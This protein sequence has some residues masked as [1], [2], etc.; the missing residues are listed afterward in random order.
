MA[1]TSTNFIAGRM[2]KSVDERLVPPGEYVDALNVRLGSTENTE[3]GAVENSLGN[4]LL[5]N[6]TYLGS[7]LGSPRTIGVYEDGINETI[8][9]FVNDENNAASPTGTVDL[10]L[11]YHTTTGN[12]TYHV[13][14]TSVL[15]FDKEYL[16]TGVN[17]IENLLFFT[18]N[19]NPP[20]MINIRKNPAYPIPVA[21]IDAL[22]E[23]D[24]SVILNPPGFEDFDPLLGQVTPLGAPHVAPITFAS[25]EE[26]YMETRF[27]SFA[28]RY[29]YED[30]GYSATSLFTTPAFQ[31]GPFQFSIQNYLNV[32]MK[33]RYNFMDVTVST[34]SKRVVEINLLYKQTTSNVIYIAKRF[35]K[36]DMGLPNNDFYTHRFSNSEI[37]TTLGSDEL[38]RLYDNVPR[39]AKAQTIQGNRLIYGNY[40]D[41]YDIRSAIDGPLIPIA[42]ESIAMW[43]SI[44][45][46]TLGN[47]ST[48]IFPNPANPIGFTGTYVSAG[49]GA[50]ITITDSIIEWD[51]SAAN[52]PIGGVINTG[53]T[54]YFSFSMS[55]DQIFCEDFGGNT[56]CGIANTFTQS[57]PFNVNL[58]FTCPVN[59]LNVDDMVSSDEFANKI[60]GASAQLL[61]SGTPFV[62]PNVVQELYPCN[63]S[64][65]GGTLSDKFYQIAPTPISGTNLELIS[66]GL[67]DA[68]SLCPT[69][70]TPWPLNC[71]TAVVVGGATSCSPGTT[72]CAPGL[73]TDV[74]VPNW[75]LVPGVIAGGLIINMNTGDTVTII[76]VNADSTLSIGAPFSSATAVADLSVDGVQYQITNP[77]GGVSPCGPYGF[78]LTPM[79]AGT[80][81]FRLQAPVTQYFSGD[82]VAPHTTNY[83][84]TFIYYSFI[85]FSTS[86][87]YLKTAD[88]GSLHSNRDY[89]VGIVYMDA[90]GR[91]STVL[92]SNN[93]SV[94]FEP[95]RSV[96]KNFIKVQL[97]NLPPYWAKKYK[98]VIKPSEG[99]YSTIYSNLFYAQD[100]TAVENTGA[101]S[102]LAKMADLSQ[103]WFRLMGDNQNIL[104]VGDEVRCK[105]DT[106][107]AVLSDARST[108]LAIEGFS[109]KGITKTSLTGLYMLIKPDG[110]S[111]ELPSNA[112]YYYPQINKDNTSTSNTAGGCINNFSLN[113]SAGLPY[114]LPAGS[115]IRIKISNW[116][117]GGGGRCNSVGIRFD[118]T[119]IATS[120]YQT[121]HQWAVGDDLQ[122]QMTTGNATNVDQ[123]TLSFNPTLNTGSGCSSTQ[124]HVTCS[125]RQDS[126]GSQFF[127]NSGGIQRCWEWTE[128]YNGHIMLKIEVSRAPGMFCFETIPQDADPNLFYDASELLDISPYVAGGQPYHR[129]QRE[130][131]P[132]GSPNPSYSLPATNIDQSFAS[133]L[134]TDLTTYNCYTFGNGVESYRI[135]DSPAG[136]GFNLG[137]RTLAVSNQDYK[138]ANRFA[139]MTYSGVFSGAANSNNLNEFN[140]G[141]LNFKDCE[142]S[143]GPIQILHSRETD[144]LCLQED[145]ISYVLSKKNVIT[146]STGGGAIAS[147]PQVLGTQIARIQE[148]GI[149]FNPES[150]T[151]WGS[152]MFFTDA[153]RGAVVNL[154]GTAKDN[155]QIQIISSLGMSTWFRNEFNARLTTQKLGAY[156]PYMNEYV[157]SSNNQSVPV[158]PDEVPC[159]SRIDQFL[160]TSPITYD[161]NLGL[162]I[163]Q[164]DV[165]YT[166][167]SGTITVTITWGGVQVVG[168]TVLTPGTGTLTFQKTSNTPQICT[169]D[170]VPSAGGSE[171]SI[172]VGCPPEVLITVVQVVIN[173]PNYDGEFIHT[174]YNWNNATNI[175][176]FAGIA[177]SLVIPQASEWESAQGIRSLGV[178]PYDGADIT[179]V[180]EKISPDDFDFDPLIHKFKILS[181]ATQ[182]SNNPTDIDTLLSTS[183]TITPIS[184]PTSGNYRA[185]ELAFNLPL[186]NEYLY[187]IWDLRMISS[188]NVCYCNGVTASATEVCC[189]CAV[190]CDSCYFG[191]LV[192]NYPTVCGSD[193]NTAGNLGL[194][195]FFG[196]GGLPQLGTQCYTNIA[197]DVSIS[198]FVDPGFYIVDSTQ[199]ATGSPKKW[200]E[201]GVNG[202]V[203]GEGLC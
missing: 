159:G 130:F 17:K 161:V 85:P 178:F 10:I 102:K 152:D 34:G 195:G 67:F 93:S 192:S 65:L 124:F 79:G 108:I 37:Y 52:P 114:D 148:Y 96:T 61:P 198:G 201:I 120:D 91:A 83:T 149:S 6:V 128:Y 135:Q 13:I 71:S 58:T 35:N 81:K 64:G 138:E 31:P 174:K 117:G 82:A 49:A 8:Y 121:F 74:N 3:I 188:Q 116:R 166:V 132:N 123:M 88:T 18:D 177:S 113:D 150:F 173:S 98:F 14:S 24:I 184:N 171:Y 57:S 38:L 145:R 1:K 193:T 23:E 4:T 56:E 104:K 36:A 163:G 167:T 191:P 162:V 186:S 48:A 7:P 89:E 146:D 76:T 2:N 170:I 160:S 109:A 153:K 68:A 100:G 155:D 165:P 60:G 97:S 115:S 199:P 77:A 50:P 32:G 54:F 66:G 63:N 142:S 92:T 110:F 40:V 90:H 106:N 30:G 147:V 141:L 84:N 187:L 129:A 33:N 189:D 154:R 202:I 140:L 111:T 127:V 126:T 107:G 46:V 72:P 185:T 151:S 42:F 47:N 86:A 144:I 11:S 180:S 118:K 182:Y 203:I 176:P 94:Y 137:E 45:G 9:W 59:Y 136:K 27:L 112:N 39:I 53:T 169:V 197:C 164:I 75:T 139:G 103:I 158:P 131:D 105:T 125:V 12:L 190:S 156:D 73:L 101:G 133:D 43:N 20:R 19:I 21:G 25:A 44:A 41:G 87:G 143:F 15:N 51:L 70:I 122:S 28:Y 196:T 179:L 200:V 26:N 168:P 183:S 62:P 55:Q 119:Y 5:T 95:N 80:G 157:L 29:R 172:T 134:Y 16:I 22:E 194:C 99:N 181:S 69:P 175:S 78:V